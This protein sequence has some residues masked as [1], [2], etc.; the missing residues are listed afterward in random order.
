ML[1]S[2]ILTAYLLLPSAA[3]APMPRIHRSSG[4]MSMSMSIS[5]G[6]LV[7]VSVTSAK[8][9]IKRALETRDYSGLSII[10]QLEARSLSQLI[11]PLIRSLQTILLHV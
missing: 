11:V 3:I 2:A 7:V 6:S 5:S 10:T 9:Q 4:T 8:A 1:F